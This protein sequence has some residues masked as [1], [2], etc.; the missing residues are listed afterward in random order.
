MIIQ[1]VAATSIMWVTRCR[2]P[3]GA[4]V[5][6]STKVPDMRPSWFNAYVEQP[7]VIQSDLVATSLLWERSPVHS[8]RK[9]FWSSE[10]MSCKPEQSLWKC[11]HFQLRSTLHQ[12]CCGRNVGDSLS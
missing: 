4:L 5:S 11:I 7:L 8:A 2:C 10:V 1:E 3:V 6:V 12:C 9:T